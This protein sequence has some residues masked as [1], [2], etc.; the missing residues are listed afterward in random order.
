MAGQPG[1]FHAAGMDKSPRIPVD[2]EQGIIDLANRMPV[3]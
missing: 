1:E 2:R 3:P